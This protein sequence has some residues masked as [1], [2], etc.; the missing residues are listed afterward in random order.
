[1]NTFAI[2]SLAYGER[3]INEFNELV[4]SLDKIDSSLNI[5]VCTDNKSKIQKQSI[6][7]IETIEPFN[8]NLKM[9]SIEAAL[10]QFNTIVCVDTDALFNL[11]TNFSILNELNDNTFYCYHKTRLI[12]YLGYK[13]SMNKLLDGTTEFDNLNDYGIALK[14]L[15]GDNNLEFMDEGIFLLSLSDISKRNEFINKWKKIIEYTKKGQRSDKNNIWLPGTFEGI[16]LNMICKELQINI[17]VYPKILIDFF[18]SFLHYGNIDGSILNK[19]L[20]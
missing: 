4:E 8:Y 5:F 15:N 18:N 12:K 13:I 17:E 10:K 1:M 16:I 6:N 2:C 19:N 20:I 14:K 9:V 11:N 7:I 3:C